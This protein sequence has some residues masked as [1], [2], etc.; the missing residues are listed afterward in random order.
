MISRSS[1]KLSLNNIKAWFI[2]EVSKSKKRTIYIVC[3]IALF[4]CTLIIVCVAL[5]INGSGK[6][7]LVGSDAPDFTRHTIW[8]EGIVSLTDCHDKP[9]VLYFWGDCPRCKQEAVNIQQILDKRNDFNVIAIDVQESIADIESRIL[10]NGLTY[11]VIRDDGN[12]ETKYQ[13]AKSI[14]RPVFVLVNKQGKISDYRFGNFSN[15]TEFENWLDAEISTQPNHNLFTDVKAWLDNELTG[16]K[17]NDNKS[18]DNTPPIIINAKIYDITNNNTSVYWETDEDSNGTVLFN[19]KYIENEKYSKSHSFILENLSPYCIYRLTIVSSD[20]FR[21]IASFSCDFTTS[22]ADYLQ[23]PHITNINT[24]FSKDSKYVSWVTSKPA[25]CFICVDRKCLAQVTPFANNH[26]ITLAESIYNFQIV[27]RAE[28][29]YCVSDVLNIEIKD[30]Q[31]QAKEQIVTG[32][33]YLKQEQWDKAIAAY[34][35]AIDLDPKSVES[36]LNRGTAYDSQGEYDKAIADYTTAIEIDPKD[37]KAYES[38]SG[39]YAGKGEYDKAI[40][41]CNKAIEIDPKFVKAYNDRGYIY[42]DITHEYDKA[43]AD[44]DK[45]IELNPNDALAYT[46]RGNTYSDKGDYDKAIADSTKAIEINPNLDYVYGNRGFAYFSKDDYAKAVADYTKAIEINPKSYMHH[47]NRGVNYYENGEYDN[48]IDDFTNAIE[49]DPKEAD[50]YTHRGIAYY[51]KGD[52]GKAKVDIYKADELNTL[53]GVETNMASNDMQQQ[54]QEHYIKGDGYFEQKQWDEAIAEYCKSIDFYPKLNM[55]VLY[56]KLAG[57]Y[58]SRGIAYNDKGEYDKAID[59]YNAAGELDPR[60]AESPLNIN[61][62][63]AYANRGHTYIEKGEYDKAIADCSKAIEIDPSIAMAYTN[64]GSAYGNKA[65]YDKAI[66][67]FTT[68]IKI[69]PKLALAYNNR[70]IAY[71]NKGD[72]GK[73]AADFQ[74]AKELGYK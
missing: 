45:A 64:R 54:A 22:S 21:N 4:V 72:M 26:V 61:L 32:D 57:A 13:I 49:I 59:D 25:R 14:G 3:G 70:G 7:S 12:I 63:Q 24:V 34:N 39:A 5:A 65:E 11:P 50:A 53:N 33:S 71:K 74:K 19:D 52:I 31:Q 10:K 17:L 43:L 40:A 67:D 44:F 69:D 35:K 41:D 46:N 20:R 47:F 38:R 29:N 30:M 2:K 56:A 6:S 18:D 8:N 62:V 60:F 27:A 68:A 1:I 16:N 28:N 23:G 15:M 48:A 9:T 37:A 66:A 55:Y 42:N 51:K 36:Y 73:A 58:Y